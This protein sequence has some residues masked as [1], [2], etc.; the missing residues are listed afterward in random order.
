MTNMLSPFGKTMKPVTPVQ[1][2]TGFNEYSEIT[3]DSGDV[4]EILMSVEQPQQTQT[5]Q[6]ASRLFANTIDTE[7]I[8]LAS[9]VRPRDRDF[10]K[11]KPKNRSILVDWMFRAAD[12]MRCLEE[13]I[14]LAVALFDR[15]AALQTIKSCHIQLFGSTCLWMA[16]K[17]EETLTPTISD[18]VYLCANAYTEAEFIDCERVILRLLKFS[19]QSTTP[20]FYTKALIEK[21]RADNATLSSW[22]QFFCSSALM[23]PS[24]GHMRPSVVAVA[25][26]FLA[27][28][29]VGETG[30]I[31]EYAVDIAEVVDCAEKITSAVAEITDA[32]SVLFLREKFNE[33]L[34]ESGLELTTIGNSLLKNVN[35]ENIIRFC[36]HK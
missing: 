2:P 14:F 19:V 36:L 22:V 33:C 16:C 29:V 26:L 7:S 8:Y 9:H 5:E 34:A 25:S 35:E 31:S 18:F 20:V 10:R 28:A 32:D 4:D 15:V 21:R 23:S 27:H 30:T 11:I 24:Y 3:E 6:Y 12:E 1:S 13:T 17:L